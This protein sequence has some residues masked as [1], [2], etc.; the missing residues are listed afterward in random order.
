MLAK[1]KPWLMLAK[2]EYYRLKLTNKKNKFFNL[3]IEIN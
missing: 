1:V 3:I 2:V